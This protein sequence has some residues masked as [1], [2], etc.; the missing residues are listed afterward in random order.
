MRSCT[1]G[2]GATHPPDPGEVRIDHPLPHRLWVVGSLCSCSS[3]TRDSPVSVSTAH[4]SSLNK[5]Y[6]RCTMVPARGVGTPTSGRT[7]CRHLS[8]R[9]AGGIQRKPDGV[10]SSGFHFYEHPFVDSFRN[11][12]TAPSPELIGTFASMRGWADE[13][14]A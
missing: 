4:T 13:Q 2:Y 7:R 10:L 6:P 9:T 3:G 12:L 5:P 8:E 14:H 1:S 11:Q